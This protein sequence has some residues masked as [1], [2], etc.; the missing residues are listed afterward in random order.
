[1]KRLPVSPTQRIEVANALSFSWQGKS[2]T[3]LSGDTVA[4]ALYANGVRIFSRSLKYHRPRGLFSLD[5][6]SANS[7]VNVNGE[8]NVTAE[9]I[10]LVEGD[11][12]RAQNYLGSVENDWL[13]CMKWFDGFMP[14][15]FYY[16]RFHKPAFLWPTA[17]KFMRKMAG[18]GVLDRTRPWPREG[19]TECFPQCDVAVLG[20]G[21]AGMSAA[22]A[23]ADQ[24]LRVILFESRPHLG[25][26]YDWRVVERE[27][28]SLF[29]RGGDLAS[30]TNAHPNIRDYTHTTAIDVSGGT[31]VT[32]IQTG[33]KNDAF[34][35]CL[36]QTR[37]RSIVVA[38]GC[39]ERP[40]VF[41][42]ND[43]PGVMLPG[44]AWRL[45]STYGIMPGT[46]AVVSIG[47]DL[48]IEAALDLAN[49]GLEVVALADLRTGDQD[50]SLLSEAIRRGIPIF[51]GQGA[52]RASGAKQV[53]SVS[54]SDLDGKVSGSFDCDLLIASAGQSPVIGPLSTVGSKLAMDAHTGFFLPREM[55]L[56][57]HCA[58][59]LLGL[60]DVSSIEASG[61][62]AGLQA[63]RDAGRKL[64]TDKA[65]KD[66]ATLPGP[67]AGNRVGYIPSEAKGRKAFICFDEDGSL[68]TA[69]QS[70]AQGFDVPE[71][72]KRFGGFGLGP[73]QGGIPGHNLPLVMSELRGD[74][75][76]DLAP[77]TVRSPLAPVMMAAMVGPQR[78]LY[79]RTPMY[80]QQQK[81][82]A[83]FEKVGA[84]K[85]ANRFGQDTACAR[86]I[87]AVHKTAGMIDVSTLG[88][89]RLYGP[90]AEKILQRVYISDMSTVAE[91]KLKYSAMLNDSGMLLDDGVATR[92]GE[93]EYYFTTS[94]ARAT[95]TEEW[96]AYHC[97]HEEW[98]YGL[99]DLTD[100]LAAI[101]LAG[102]QSREILS[103]VTDADLSNAA[104]PYMGYREIL[105]TGDTPIQLLRIGFLGELSYE[106]HFPASYGPTV[107]N[108]LMDAGQGSGLLPIGLEAQNVCR[109]E[110][111][112]VIIGI[113]SEQRVNLVDLGLGFLWDHSDTDSGKIGSPALK[114]TENQKGRMKLAGIRMDEGES[115]PG[116][117]AIIVQGDVI[118]GHICTARQSAAVGASIALVLVADEL[119]LP[120]TPIRIY[121]NEGH[122]EAWYSAHVV[123]TPFYD[124]E[125]TKLR[126]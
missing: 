10:P 74:D 78:L 20:G 55:P 107:W 17:C 68:K 73:S 96:I 113:E 118:K 57:I 16:H 123:Q 14:A 35:Q 82:G 29:K 117:G 125:G 46:R 115:C 26:F 59:R 1:M 2:M 56:R 75:T 80:D 43:K 86:E 9:M 108:L 70:V 105:L 104:M 126:S 6:Q 88:K 94:S 110:K 63:A 121:Q 60:A 106:L 51:K 87:E 36:L 91:G 15:G 13:A 79:K 34:R 41:E 53:E 65:E 48:G 120:G 93:G 39:L 84:W 66:L 124:P 62:L 45:A 25:G 4:S 58:G 85:R 37:P 99:V 100:H 81:L 67:V 71:L 21:P 90:D 103:A 5:G 40:L 114:F 54:L 109:M 18:T 95:V 22:L 98:D 92:V 89:F 112:H 102:P 8:C 119:A 28:Q 24:G 27:G 50:E 3:G 61:R 23:A 69:K 72:A 77:T 19:Y 11:K 44:C 122:G 101:N 97:R 49:L 33:T 47:D 30:R 38:T 32:A 42:E 52:A 116:D 76:L 83:V 7:L 31:L 12:V 111:G 64:S